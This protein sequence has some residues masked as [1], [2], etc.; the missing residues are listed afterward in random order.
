[1]ENVAVQLLSA[2]T[3]T[4]T[5]ATAPLQSPLQTTKLQ[6]SAGDAVSVT[7]V[8]VSNAAEQEAPQSMPAALLVTVPEPTTTALRVLVPGVPGAKGSVPATVPS[9]PPPQ[10]KEK[11]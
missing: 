5:A 3:V 9:P 6:M 1:M 2:S 8:P 4:G 10:P 11:R 7:S